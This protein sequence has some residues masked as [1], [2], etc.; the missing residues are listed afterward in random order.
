[1]KIRI[2]TRENGEVV[3]KWVEAEDTEAQ[4]NGPSEQELKEI[5]KYRSLGEIATL[6]EELASTDYKVA[7]IAECSA[8]GLEMPYDVAALH[9][10]R[11]AI[12]DRINELEGG[13]YE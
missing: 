13:A 2:K 12:R 11:Q 5:E 9:K 8:L 1:M 7:K 10:E 3:E 6:K 4:A